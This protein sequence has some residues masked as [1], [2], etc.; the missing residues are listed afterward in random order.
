MREYVVVWISVRAY[1]RARLAAALVVDASEERVTAEDGPEEKFAVM[2]R[3]QA[4]ESARAAAMFKGVNVAEF[5]ERALM[6]H[7]TDG[8]HPLLAGGDFESD[9]KD[10]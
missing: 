3:A 5:I 7:W 6:R 4:F 2:I 10:E 9:P 8:I 1:R